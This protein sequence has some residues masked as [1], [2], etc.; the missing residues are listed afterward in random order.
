MFPFLRYYARYG[1]VYEQFLAFVSKSFINKSR[2][3]LM[4]IRLYEIS[5]SPLN[6][7]LILRIMSKRPDN[8]SNGMERFQ[9]IGIY[10]GF[11]DGF[12]C[13]IVY[14]PQSLFTSWKRFPI[15]IS[16]LRNSRTGSKVCIC[17][18]SSW[19]TFITAGGKGQQ[20]NN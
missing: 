4:A 3:F 5:S 7:V 15:I 20:G 12:T 19:W 18:N 1:Y 16:Y 10:I 8:D 6:K 17:L 11:Y 9:A 14:C 13:V 2:V